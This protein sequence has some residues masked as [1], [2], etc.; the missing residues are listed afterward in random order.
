MKKNIIHTFFIALLV[1][2]AE[3]VSANGDILVGDLN[4]VV[5]FARFKG[6]PDFDENKTY[7]NNF[8]NGEDSRSMKSYFKAISN[9]KL[10]VNSLIYPTSETDRSFHLKYS[11]FCYEPDWSKDFAECKG[12]D[13]SSLSDISIGFVIKDLASKIESQM[14]DASIDK[15]NDGYVDDFVIVLNGAGRG[16]N[17]GIH[18][19]HIGEISERFTS[20]NGEIAIKGKKIKK[21]TIVYERN[22]LDTHCRFLLNSLGFPNLYKGRTTAPRPV[23][24]WDVMDGPQLTYPL[25]YNRYK[26]SEGQWINSIPTVESNKTYT[27]NSTDQ[28]SNNA[29]KIPTSNDDEFFIVEFRNNAN[30]Y[31]NH[32]PESGMI[33]YRVNTTQSGSAGQTPEFYVFR[34]DGTLTL[35]GDLFS[36]AFRQDNGRNIFNPT[37]NPSP[38]DSTGKAV[39]LNL[40]NIKVEAGVVTFETGNVPTSSIIDNTSDNAIAI[41]PNPAKD[42]ITVKGNWNRIK[43]IDMNGTTVLNQVLDASQL[44]QMIDVQTLTRGFYMIEIQGLES[45]KRIKLILN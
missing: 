11:F 29:F 23:G 12:S 24:I 41:F 8:F 5:V 43:I 19:P 36:A 2:V 30:I 18:T 31:D 35:D 26:Y 3:T 13:I 34:K 4:R 45:Q 10:N 6:D 22:S 7:Y 1:I 42:F 14:T 21:Y 15:D 32:L 33:I 17:E 20:T 38:F 28:S 39:E 27:L 9:D 37:S 40:K 44:E 25:V 16:K